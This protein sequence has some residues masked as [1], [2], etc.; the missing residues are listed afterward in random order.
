M[1]HRLFFLFFLFFLLFPCTAV[2]QLTPELRRD[3]ILTF[4][5]NE[6]TG[7][8]HAAAVARVLS[9]ADVETG[10][11]MLADLTHI[12][13]PDVVERFRL[14]TAYVLLYKS[15]PVEI[16]EDIEHVWAVLPVYPLM[17]ESERVCYYASLY[18]TTKV[19]PPEARWFNGRSRLEN[20]NDSRSFLLHWMRETSET[21]EEDFDSPTYGAAVFCAML[22]LRD[23]SGDSVLSRRAELMAQWLLADFAHDYLAGAHAGAHSRE[24]MLSAVHPVTS[25]MSAIA[26]LYFGDGPRL[27]GREQYFAALSDFEAL[28]EIIE[29]ATD[30]QEAY[31]AWEAK[32]SAPLF[33]D[34][35]LARGGPLWKYT[36]MDPLYAIGSIPGGLIQP[37]EQHSWDVTWIPE[38]PESPAT[39]YLMQPYADPNALT[40]FLPHSEEIALRVTSTFDSYYSTVTRT[41]GGSPFEDVF[42]YRN[43][44]IA[45]YDIGQVTRFP[46]LTGILPSHVKRM[47]VDT[48]RSGWITINTGDVY[49]G[50]YPLKRFRIA[51]GPFGRVFSSP[52][53][54]NGAIVQVA[55]RNVI[56][57]YDQFLKR[58]RASHVDASR[59]DTE[60]QISYTT[61]FGDTLRMQY[62]GGRYVNGKPYAPPPD[63]LLFTGTRLFSARGSGV[64]TI[65]SSTGDVHIDIKKL[66]IRKD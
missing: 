6:E 34:N 9:G 5:A 40:P 58:I 62:Q 14:T 3:S 32:R 30:R 28:P 25:D 63:D 52:E 16:R 26:W 45:L 61:M 24:F 7:T 8:N 49:I 46:L 41:V 29:L 66:E 43:T 4:F 55:G 39:L 23:H 64:L 44:L 57:S 54:R 53:R 47:D 56:G 15:M 18:L 51:D 38:N 37:R 27:Y 2:S 36:Y 10:Y 42:Q 59:F 35:G 1:I 22:L 12:A 65:R 31:E 19:F 60:R 11:G 21:G 48:V 17:G 13:T 50:L 33:R 20:E